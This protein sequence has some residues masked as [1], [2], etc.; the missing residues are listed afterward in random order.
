MP[1]T[2]DL[3]TSMHAIFPK[4]CV[5]CGAPPRAIWTARAVKGIDLIAFRV[6]RVYEI[7]LPL[8]RA[9]VWRRAGIGGIAAVLIGIGVPIGAIL[10]WGTVFLNHGRRPGDA[11]TTALMATVIAALYYV[12]N[13]HSRVMDRFFLGVSGAGLDEHR[14]VARL[15]VRDDRLAEEIHSEPIPVKYVD[16]HAHATESERYEYQ[17]RTWWFKCL[18]GA[19]FLWV[20]FITWQDLSDL[21][22]GRAQTVQ[23]WAPLAMLYRVAG[24]WPSVLI[25]A[26]PGAAFVAWGLW[27]LGRKLFIQAAE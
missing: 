14:G 7:T 26:L 11:A 12:R 15:W 4:R 23:V 20:S 22:R 5:C 27:Q 2:I 6:R 10:V 3:D 18:V 13:V 16:R 21:E 1:R 25:L 9:C 17:R 19:V 24:L 8:C